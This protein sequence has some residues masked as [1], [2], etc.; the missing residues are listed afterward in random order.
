[1]KNVTNNLAKKENIVSGKSQLVETFSKFCKI[2]YNYCKYCQ[3]II[4][5]EFYY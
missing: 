4:D 2:C 5:K 1:M 3:Y